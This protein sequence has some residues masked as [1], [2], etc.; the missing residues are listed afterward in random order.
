M[1]R[2]TKSN[3]GGLRVPLPSEGKRRG[4]K[5]L[6]L[7]ELLL[8]SAAGLA[9]VCWVVVSPPFLRAMA[10]WLDVGEPPRKADYVLILGGDE[11]TR[12]FA[13][14]ALVRAGWA[15]RVLM[16]ENAPS[17]AEIDGVIPRQAEITRQVLVH[18]GVPAK[19]FTLLPGE[20]VSTYDEAC[21]LA[22]FLQ[23]H[24]RARVLVVTND[25]HTRRSR[26]VF[27]RVLG[28]RAGQI[29]LISAPSDDFPI[30]RWWRSQSGFLFVT[31]EYLK[32]GFYAV[33]YGRLGYWL[34]ACAALAV[35]ATCLRRRVPPSPTALQIAAAQGRPAH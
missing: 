8:L 1:S 30:N 31:T 21:G 20:A 19:R 26:W 25:L 34:A 28:D 4:K 18:R 32:L 10:A 17:L 14:A 23:R 9:L 33:A 12:P 5:F 29:S 11:N 3:E 22:A 7:L 15:P 13:A 2:D 35:I 16:V 27:T 24:P 6:R